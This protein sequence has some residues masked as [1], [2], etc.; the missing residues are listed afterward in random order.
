[1]K[2]LNHHRRY[3]IVALLL[4]IVVS[5]STF[6]HPGQ[7]LQRL[8]G[9]V[10]VSGW[11]LTSEICKGR[12]QVL[13]ISTTPTRDSIS[14]QFAFLP[15]C[16]DC[17]L[18]SIQGQKSH[19]I[20]ELGRCGTE[21]EKC[22]KEHENDSTS[23]GLRKKIQNLQGQIGFS[24]PSQISSN[25]L[26]LGDF[27]GELRQLDKE[28]LEAQ[29]ALADYE[30]NLCTNLSPEVRPDLSEFPPVDLNFT[31]GPDTNP[32]LGSGEAN[33]KTEETRPE[34]SQPF[35]PQQVSF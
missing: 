25:A 35:N 24:N 8:K 10:I 4:V 13:G 1:M 27:A 9:E 23:A 28:T 33:K 22:Q 12:H 20:S 3:A 15:E 31:W 17:G 6:F 7:N 16:Q 5:A 11:G 30:K 32:I 18:W 14:Q 29:K 34:L 19:W 2:F 21:F 26:L